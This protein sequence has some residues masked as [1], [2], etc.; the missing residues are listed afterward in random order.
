MAST[1]LVMHVLGSTLN[2]NIG[3]GEKWSEG[4]ELMEW[5]RNLFRSGKTKERTVNGKRIVFKDM[6]PLGFQLSIL[7]KRGTVEPDDILTEMMK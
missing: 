1:I 2:P 7:P 4:D 3:S 5:T 6:F